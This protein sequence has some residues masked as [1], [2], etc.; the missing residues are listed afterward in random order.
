MSHSDPFTLELPFDDPSPR[1]VKGSIS[2]DHSKKGVNRFG[3]PKFHNAYRATVTY[4][5]KKYRKRSIDRA[6]CERFLQQLAD[7]HSKGLL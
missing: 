6:D 4:N 1:R 3:Q 2:F 5:G 7:L